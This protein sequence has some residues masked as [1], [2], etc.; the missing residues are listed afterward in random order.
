MFISIFSIDFNLY[1][2]RKIYESAYGIMSLNYYLIY[3]Q[4]VKNLSST[5]KNFE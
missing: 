1:F 5:K 4:S 3:P 2:F